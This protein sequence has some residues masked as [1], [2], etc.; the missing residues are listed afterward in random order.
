MFHSTWEKPGSALGTGGRI[1]M[2]SSITS[3]N[4]LTLISDT[5]KPLI[6]CM[7]IGITSALNLWV[8]S[9]MSLSCARSVNRARPGRPRHLW[10]EV[11]VNNKFLFSVIARIL[12]M[13]RRNSVSCREYESW[14]PQLTRTR[15][16]IT[17]DSG[18]TSE[19]P[20]LLPLLGG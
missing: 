3:L 20:Q 2:C 13:V 18:A 15:N 14:P 12:D 19:K 10:L 17:R 1:A 11:D 6:R 7:R 9:S 8:A 5:F 16:P 4:A